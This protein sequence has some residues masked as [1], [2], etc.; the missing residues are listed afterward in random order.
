MSFALPVTTSV[1]SLATLNRTLSDGT[2]VW[3]SLVLVGQQPVPMLNVRYSWK[4][5]WAIRNHGWLGAASEKS[6]LCTFLIDGRAI[7]V[8]TAVV[9]ATG[10]AI[11]KFA[12]QAFAVKKCLQMRMSLPPYPPFYGTAKY[13]VRCTI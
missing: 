6:I 4:R 2:K 1:A 3:T 13:S 12:M 7:A 10:Y 9:L 5:M 11:Y 8:C